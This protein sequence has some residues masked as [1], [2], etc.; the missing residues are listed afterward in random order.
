MPSF[1]TEV[2]ARTLRFTHFS[3]YETLLLL[4]NPQTVERDL[5]EYTDFKKTVQI[6]PSLGASTAKKALL[7]HYPTNT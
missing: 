1:A 7:I 3:K 2:Y 5:G 4:Y 6:A